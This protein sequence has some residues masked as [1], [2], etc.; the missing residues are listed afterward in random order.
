MGNAEEFVA[1]AHI[2]ID[3]VD[4]LVLKDAEIGQSAAT[5]RR[6]CDGHAIGGLISRSQLGMNSTGSVSVISTANRDTRK[7]PSP[8]RAARAF[9]ASQRIAA[10]GAGART[11]HRPAESQVGG[12]W[13]SARR[14]S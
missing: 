6:R 7:S 11:Y 1:G 3:R 14:Q 9:T 10:A 13:V 5:A 8:C 2:K 12:S 4:V